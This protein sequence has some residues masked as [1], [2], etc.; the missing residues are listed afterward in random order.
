M[1][2]VAGGMVS[3]LIFGGNVGEAT[4]RGAAWGATTGAVSGAMVGVMISSEPIF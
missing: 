1:G 4:A 2:A 3:A